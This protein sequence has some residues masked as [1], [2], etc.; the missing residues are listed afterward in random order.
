MRI[1]FCSDPFEAR[2]P[3]SEYEAE[4]AVTQSLGIEHDL[5]SYEALVYNHD[6][7]AAVRAVRALSNPELA[8]YRGWMLKPGDYKQLYDALANRGAHLINDPNAYIHCH[9]LPESYPV[10]EQHTPKTVWTRTESVTL[11]FPPPIW[12]TSHFRSPG[13]PGHLSCMRAYPGITS[14]SCFR[15]RMRIRFAGITMTQ[16]RMKASAF[17]RKN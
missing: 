10:I 8:V 4:V 14:S 15:G 11:K 12:T 1:T 9:Y 7:E 13:T 16:A 6:P 2:K 3:D 17:T 5:I